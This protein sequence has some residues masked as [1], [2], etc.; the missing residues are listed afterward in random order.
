MAQEIRDP[1][2]IA[3]LA[4]GIRQNIVDYAEA[5]GPCSVADL[6]RALGRA[7]DS[8]YYHVRI[9]LRAELL[10]E[11][12]TRGEGREA[13]ALVDVAARPLAIRYDD[14]NDNNLDAVRDLS[15]AMLRL[16]QRDFSRGLAAP[17]VRLHGPRRQVWTGRHVGRL[18]RDELA[19]VNAHVEAIGR[20]F[21]S[22][23]QRR[24]GHL[25]TFTFSSAPV[26]PND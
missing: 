15:A 3:V 8:L 19:A 21:L 16:A 1:E 13:E 26:A 24:D 11:R 25:Q 2:Q 22:S 9:L 18:T 7:A 5:L 10:V 17:D 12:G 4:S 20:I 6:A 14:E 23:Y